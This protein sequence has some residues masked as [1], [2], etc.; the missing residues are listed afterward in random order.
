MPVA[1]T[2]FNIFRQLF[3]LY[4]CFFYATQRMICSVT[5]TAAHAIKATVIML[6]SKYA[7]MQAAT[8]PTM[9]EIR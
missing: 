8:K 2:I 3:Q 9:P 5:N 1:S 6:R 4:F 7:A